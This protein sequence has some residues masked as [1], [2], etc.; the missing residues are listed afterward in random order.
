[1]RVWV[2][3]DLCTGC[4]LCVDKCPAVFEMEDGIAFAASRVPEDEEVRVEDAIDECPVEAIIL[5]D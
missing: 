5:E 1:M 3:E 4:G 2:D